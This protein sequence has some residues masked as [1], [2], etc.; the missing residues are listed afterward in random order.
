LI[1]CWDEF[2]VQEIGAFC[3]QHFAPEL[4]EL[5]IYRWDA[6]LDTWKDSVECG[7]WGMFVLEH[8]RALLPGKLMCQAVNFLQVLAELQLGKCHRPIVWCL[9]KIRFKKIL[10]KNLSHTLLI[11]QLTLQVPVPGV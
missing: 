11:A 4:N 10:A 7:F 5:S 3:G 8:S 6:F 9:P 2:F 1:H